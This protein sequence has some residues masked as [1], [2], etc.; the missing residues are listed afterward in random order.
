MQSPTGNNGLCEKR[1][2]LLELERLIPFLIEKKHPSNF[3]VMEDL[4]NYNTLE[5]IIK[6][7]RGNSDGMNTRELNWNG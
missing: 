2:I 7:I 4:D 6:E 5:N 1:L 3:Y